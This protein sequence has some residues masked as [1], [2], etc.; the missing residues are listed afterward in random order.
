MPEKADVAVI[1]AGVAGLTTA[2]R[3]KE[4]GRSVLVIDQGDPFRGGSGVNA[5]TLALQNKKAELILF[6]QRAIAEWRRLDEVLDGDI[7]YV[8]RGGLRVA[9]SK[10]EAETLRLEVARQKE[11]GI[12]TEWLEGNRLR[13]HAPWLGPS[14][15]C[16]TYCVDDGFAS[17]L[18]VGRALVKA[19]LGAGV[20]VAT[21]REFLGQTT[22][23][24][25]Y[26][27]DTSAGPV[28]CGDVVIAAGAWSGR[29]AEHFGVTLPVECHVNMLSVTRRIAQ[30]MDNQVVTH[31]GGRL[32]LKQYPNGSCL[33]GGGWRGEGG[34]ETGRKDLNSERLQQNLRL[35]ADVV[36]PLK[37]VTILRT[38]A[39][40]EAE[41]PDHWP[42]AGG[43]AGHPRLFVAVPA[44]AG[45][46]A[47]PIVGRLTAEKL[48]T[49]E[50]PPFA[51]PM[52]PERFL[53]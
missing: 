32:T 52:D 21:N 27:L 22:T 43:F 18:L 31:I 41:T 38:W 8:C 1:G 45:F 5:G 39:G 35:H 34:I 9:E 40:F 29:V 20:G 24:N 10:D 11:L 13:H 50:M 16:A 6:Y 53:H 37:D 51:R 4:G 49:G 23:P 19:A 17:P 12:E 44:K 3:L 15:G 48:L 33:L 42:I 7:G 47:G 46:T 28:E 30:F 36:P 14:V 2:L 25:G 26:R